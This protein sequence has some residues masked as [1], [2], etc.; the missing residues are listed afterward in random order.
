MI[1]VQLVDDNDLVRSG[2]RTLLVADPDISVVAEATDGRKAVN[3][4]QRYRPDLILMDIRM[5]VLDGIQATRQIRADPDLAAIRVVMLTTFDD[6]EEVSGA[7]RAG[8]SGYLLKDTPAD[9]LRAHVH[10]VAAGEP[11]LSPRVTGRVMDMIATHPGGW[12]TND[13]RLA[14]LNERELEMLARIGQ[15]ETNDEIAAALFLSPATSR[16]YVS[17]LLGK[18]GARDRAELIILAI[19]SG[20]A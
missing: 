8:A 14:T 16:T 10:R 1:R 15:G 4:A 17:R 12:A 13:A 9:E 7:I 6:E 3:A 5:P 18:L 2:L 19:R 20:L 11:I